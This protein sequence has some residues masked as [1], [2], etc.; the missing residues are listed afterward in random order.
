MTTATTEAL[1][2][3]GDGV[4]VN[5][6]SDRYP[7]TVVATRR[8][9]KEVDVQMDSYVL[10]SGSEFTGDA[11]YAIGP[12]SDGHIETY[13]Y[14]DLGEGKFAFVLKGESTRGMRPRRITPGRR[15]FMDPSF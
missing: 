10:S 12:N 11:V 2:T 1:P 5:G 4:T 14:R 6:W 7:G 15:V 3:I 9:G 13:T 8:N